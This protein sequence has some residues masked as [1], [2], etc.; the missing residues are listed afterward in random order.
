L[1]IDAEIAYGESS[2]AVK[3][4]QILFIGTD[5]I[6]ET[7]NEKDELFGKDRLK[8]V[9]RQHAGRSARDILLAVYDTVEEF[10]GDLKPEDDLTIVVIKLNEE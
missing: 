4:G 3:D 9:I 6:W 7:R 8:N 10:R 1:G 5:G 2:T